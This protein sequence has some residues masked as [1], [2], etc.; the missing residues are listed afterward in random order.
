MST[1]TTLNSFTDFVH[2][3]LKE[4]RTSSI[5]TYFEDIFIRAKE[6]LHGIQYTPESRAEVTKCLTRPQNIQKLFETT[7]SDPDKT[8][9]GVEDHLERWLLRETLNCA[10]EAA[11]KLPPNLEARPTP[12]SEATLDRF[13]EAGNCV[14]EVFKDSC[15]PCHLNEAKIKCAAKHLYPKYPLY[16]IP[17]DRAKALFPDLSKQVKGTPEL[18]EYNAQTST[19]T[20][21][22]QERVWNAIEDHCSK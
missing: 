5:H 22:D 20:L 11:Q 8:M 15:V 10:T 17:L 3:W 13:K 2:S 9:S 18:Y 16:T 4:E 12:L 21:L 1:S 6:Q 19:Y 14:V 7:S